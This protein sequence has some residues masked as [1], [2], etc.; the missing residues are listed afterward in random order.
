MTGIEGGQR[1]R[2][3]LRTPSRRPE[4]S[5]L[6]HLAPAFKLALDALSELGRRAL[7]LVE[8][9][10]I[11][12]LLHVRQPGDV[13]NAAVEQVDDLLARAGRDQN[14]EPLISGENRIA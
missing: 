6:D 5:R 14:S 9:E 12:A 4:V 8:I 7:D 3:T 10:G 2:K 1:N 11:E 13:D